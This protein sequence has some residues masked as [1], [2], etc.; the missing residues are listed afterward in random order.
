[1]GGGCRS[2]DIEQCL[3]SAPGAGCVCIDVDLTLID[4]AEAAR[5]QYDKAVGGGPAC[6]VARG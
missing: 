5:A 4:V 1:M 6:A 2:G 3:F